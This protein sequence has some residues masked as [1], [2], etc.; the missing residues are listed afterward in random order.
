[1]KKLMLFVA[2]G[3][4]A[5]LQSTADY[6]KWMVDSSLVSSATARSDIQGG[7][8]TVARNNLQNYAYAALVVGNSADHGD[9]PLVSTEIKSYVGDSAAATPLMS[10]DIVANG[11]SIAVADIGSN[12]KYFFIELYSATGDL[13]GYTT[14]G[15]TKSELSAF[16]ET[17]RFAADWSTTSAWGGGGFTAVPEPTGGLMILLG[18]GLIG[19]RRKKFI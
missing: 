10:R 2:I 4:A 19:L 11:A 6:M 18:A 3:A 12:D 9:A 15:Q 16:V 8:A 1:M 13:L 7:N 17:S 14:T 5:S